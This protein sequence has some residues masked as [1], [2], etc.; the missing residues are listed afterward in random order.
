MIV[1]TEFFTTILSQN[2]DNY[3]KVIAAFRL[4]RVVKVDEAFIGLHQVVW[5]THLSLATF[6][7]DTVSSLEF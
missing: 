5:E 3:H 6:T 1:L 2:L 7:H 4:N